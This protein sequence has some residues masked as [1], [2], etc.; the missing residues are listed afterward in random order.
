MAEGE[1][2]RFE[3][4]VNGGIDLISKTAGS[5]TGLLGPE[6][7]LLGGGVE[8]ISGQLLRRVG[9][10]V[11]NMVGRGAAERAGGALL[12]IQADAAEHQRDRD[13]PRSDGFA[14]SRDGQRPDSEELLEGVLLHAAQSY[15]QRKVVLL[16]HLYDGL[17][18]DSQINAGQ[19]HYLLK[20]A[21]RLTYEQLVALS[22]FQDEKHLDT[23]ATASYRRDEGQ[24]APSDTIALEIDD[25][26]DQG[27]L[28]VRVEGGD[29]TARPAE[30]W[31]SSGRA[32]AKP[33]QDLKLMPVGLSMH[34][35]MR[36]STIPADDQNHF[37][38]ELDIPV[39][40]APE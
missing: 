5:S 17:A 19:G 3:R 24:V 22:V 25:L 16:A 6:G 14:E 11:V 33:F 15:E 36:L 7:A 38:G 18:F 30:L 39:H 29:E 27:V 12:V 37:I 10:M 28:G 31:G 9:T 32:S 34:R 23:L 2:E 20:L 40:S 26:A 21:A 13:T 35:L 4:A 8:W 1:S